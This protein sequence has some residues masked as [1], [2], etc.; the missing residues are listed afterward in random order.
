MSSKSARFKTITSYLEFSELVMRSKGEWV[1]NYGPP[2]LYPPM[3]PPCFPH[4]Q[5]ACLWSSLLN[6]IS[7]RDG[8]GEDQLVPLPLFP[9]NSSPFH[10]PQWRLNCVSVFP[11][12]L[13]LSP[14]GAEDGSTLSFPLDLSPVRERREIMAKWETEDEH[15]PCTNRWTTCPRKRRIDVLFS[16]LS[17]FRTLSR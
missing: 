4:N 15:G 10:C 1:R 11:P 17:Q 2:R 7:N 12:I 6:Q 13:P 5:R 16:W 9:Q 8:R 3:L 14:Q